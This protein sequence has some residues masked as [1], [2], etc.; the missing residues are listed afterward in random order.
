MNKK[1]MKPFAAAAIAG[2]LLVGGWSWSAGG[3]ALAQEAAAT[4]NFVSV[5]GKGEIEVK[6]DIAYLSIGAS[7][8][9]DTAA[10][11]KKR[12]QPKFKRSLHS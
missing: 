6:P 5:T 7:S 1:W 8:E 10:R 12:M 11:H 2:A 4:Q 3:T 9:A